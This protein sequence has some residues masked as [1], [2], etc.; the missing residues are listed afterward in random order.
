[1]LLYKAGAKRLAT[2]A[3]IIALLASPFLWK[4]DCLTAVCEGELIFA[5]P[6]AEGESFELTFTHSLNLSPITDVI[7]WTGG[8]L[9]VRKSVF[10]A[11]GA[12]VPVPSDGAGKELIKV[13]STYELV[14]IDKSLGEFSIMTQDIPNHRISFKGREA[15]LLKLA[16]SG[17]TVQVAVKQLSVAEILKLS[18]E[19]EDY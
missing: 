7:E 11:F 10:K 12:G 5:C 9:I 6:I 16:G 13:G 4:V 1:M 3:V 18:F 14:G 15:Y 2:A 8:D 19:T 17:N